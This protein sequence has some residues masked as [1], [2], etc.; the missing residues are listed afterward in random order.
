MLAFECILALNAQFREH[1]DGCMSNCPR[2]CKW[3]FQSNNMKGYP[4]EDLYNAFGETK[5][6]VWYCFGFLVLLSEWDKISIFLFYFQVIKSV[7][8]ST[9]DEETPMARIME[10]EADYENEEGPSNLWSLWLTVKEKSIWWKD[11]Y[12]LNVA[13]RDFSTKKDKRKVNEKAS[14]SNASLEDVLK[15][16][17]KRL[18]TCLSE[19]N[20]KVE[21]MNKRLC[22]M[23][24]SQVV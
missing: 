17:E 13:A 24:K 1:V 2:M 8:A 14:S 23:E 3:R 6:C 9:I 21:T 5:V 15:G 19:V 20:V 10:D 7:I 11:L 16:I 4:L 22:V 18:M 12:E